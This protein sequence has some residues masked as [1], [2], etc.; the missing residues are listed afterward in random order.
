ML[1]EFVY[2]LLKCVADDLEVLFTQTKVINNLCFIVHFILFNP[3]ITRHFLKLA[4]FL[5][6]SGQS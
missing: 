2:V 3:N 5:L 6:I 1:R 4:V